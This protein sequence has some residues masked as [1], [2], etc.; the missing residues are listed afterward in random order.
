MC[1]DH[2][3]KIFDLV[4]VRERVWRLTETSNDDKLFSE[5]TQLGK[6]LI[7][8]YVSRTTVPRLAAALLTY[9]LNFA[10]GAL[11]SLRC[12]QCSCQLLSTT[13]LGNGFRLESF[14]F[15]G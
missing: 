13:V 6:H 11:K 2:N 10:L 1:I 7:Y 12:L 15:A 8:A 3:R 9:M 14:L 4:Q 5:H